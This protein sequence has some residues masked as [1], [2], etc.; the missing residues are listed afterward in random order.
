VRGGALALEAV[1]AE[2]EAAA[3]YYRLRGPI[4]R[5]GARFRVDAAARPL[6]EIVLR[7]TRLGERTLITRHGALPLA[8]AAGDGHRVRITVRPLAR[9]LLW[10]ETRTTP[11][12]W[13][14][15]SSH[16]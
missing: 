1:E 12:M 11:W 13:E 4:R 15:A 7:A 16:D 8:V 3:E 5:H 2:R 10:W 6:P 14:E 9:A